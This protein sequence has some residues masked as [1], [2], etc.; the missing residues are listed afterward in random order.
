MKLYFPLFH[1][2]N[3][4][5]PF[6]DFKIPAGF[7][8]PALDHMEER[9]DLLKEIVKHPLATFYCRNEGDSM[10][11]ACIPPGSILVVDKSVTPRSG[12][13]VVAYL[14]GGWTVKYIQFSAQKCFLIPANKSKKYPV[15]EVTEDMEMIVWGKVTS[16]IIDTK[17][18]R[19]CT[20]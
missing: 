10:I 12:D 11:D 16:V 6:F 5:I 7:P 19:L 20:R 18:I 15:T 8:S 1:S 3:N 14:N 13:I 4:N 2:N 9:I 17:N